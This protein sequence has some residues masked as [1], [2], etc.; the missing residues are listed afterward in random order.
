[1]SAAYNKAIHEISSHIRS[2]MTP[3]EAR[4]AANEAQNVYLALDLDDADVLFVIGCRAVALGAH[5]F[6]AFTS[7]YAR[8]LS[9]APIDDCTGDSRI[10]Y[11]AGL[12]AARET[13][14]VIDMPVTQAVK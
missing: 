1:M 11:E 13:P 6:D 12:R 14:S 8:G 9:G 2:T 7:G 10:G 4:D 3:D 5:D